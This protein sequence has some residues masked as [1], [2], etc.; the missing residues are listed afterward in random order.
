MRIGVPKQ[1]ISNIS[2]SSIKKLCKNNY[3]HILIKLNSGQIKF[4]ISKSEEL[5]ERAYEAE[6]KDDKKEFGRLL[7]YPECCVNFF[8]DISLRRKYNKNEFPYL[9]HSFFEDKK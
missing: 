2:L 4:Y 9:I 6:K 3:L 1:F 7:G 8:S 5:L